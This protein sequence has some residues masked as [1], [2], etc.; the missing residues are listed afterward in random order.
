MSSN[1]I[2]VL[3]DAL[4]NEYVTLSKNMSGQYVCQYDFC[5]VKDGPVLIGTFGKGNT[6]EKA[7]EDYIQQI[8]GKTLVFHAGSDNEHKARVAILQKVVYVGENI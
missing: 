5:D 2:E 8:T 7:A 4:P 3:I 6:I 1:P